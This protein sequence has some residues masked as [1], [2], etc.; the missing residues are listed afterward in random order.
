MSNTTWV[1]HL[2]DLK[3]NETKVKLFLDNSTMLQGKITAFDEDS[4]VID[5]CLV[6]REHV[7]SIALHRV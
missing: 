2:Q 3:K 1:N 7:V 4:I 6:N 5:S